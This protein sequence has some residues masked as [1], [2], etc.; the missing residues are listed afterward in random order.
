MRSW[1]LRTINLAQLY[2]NHF[3]F[4]AL[5]AVI[6]EEADKKPINEFGA[7]NKDDGQPEINGH[8]VGIGKIYHGGEQFD[9]KCRFRIAGSRQRIVEDH[10]RN[11][12][13]HGKIHQPDDFRGFMDQMG[14]IRVNLRQ[15]LR[16]KENQRCEKQDQ[17][18]GYR[19]QFPEQNRNRRG[20]PLPDQIARK[21]VR[22]G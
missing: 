5:E 16:S 4:P 19:D 18:Q 11:K 9:D 1:K 12:G 7:P 2:L 21:G 14:I 6:A 15:Q 10:P 8:Q 13:K 17:H 22:R 3:P 20:F